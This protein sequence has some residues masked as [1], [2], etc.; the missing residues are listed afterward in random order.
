MSARL[1]GMTELLL[2]YGCEV[3]VERTPRGRTQRHLYDPQD[4]RQSVLCKAVD[5]GS[6]ELVR[7]LLSHGAD[8][9]RDM[10][11]SPFYI[12]SIVL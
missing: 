5:R 12:I 6:L 4:K 9:N 7:L 10:L 2:S 8:V 3:D 11:V 1:V